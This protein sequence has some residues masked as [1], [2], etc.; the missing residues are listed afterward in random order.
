MS[1][2]A[3]MKRLRKSAIKRGWRD[4]TKSRR[5]RSHYILEWV[6]GERVTMS[7]SPSCSHAMKNCAADLRRVERR[8][9]DN[10]DA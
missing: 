1:D 2:K 3:D 7:L 9:V 4:I 10:P 6:S 5:R 8:G